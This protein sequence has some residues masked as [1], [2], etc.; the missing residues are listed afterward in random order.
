[1]RRSCDL[2]PTPF[3]IISKTDFF[4]GSFRDNTG[5][6]ELIHAD[7]SHSLNFCPFEESRNRLRV[8]EAPEAPKSPESSRGAPDIYPAIK[9][10]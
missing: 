9:S 5:R 10:T 3:D 7:Y 4:R 6:K 1:M 8:P 2:A